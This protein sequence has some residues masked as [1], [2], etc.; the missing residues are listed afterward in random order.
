[1]SYCQKHHHS[2][3]AAPQLERRDRCFKIRVINCETRE[4][5]DA[6]DSCVYVALSYVWGAY[7]PQMTVPCSSDGSKS[8]H[9]PAELPR[10]IEDAII[11]YC[12]NQGDAR[13]LHRQLDL[14][15]LIYNF[16]A[17]TL[18][19]AAGDNASFGLPGVSHPR[20][21]Q[22]TIS[23]DGQLWVSALED[24]RRCV[25]RSTWN[26]RA[27]TFQ[28]G[29][30]ARQRL[31]FTTDQVAFECNGADFFE[32]ARRAYRNDGKDFQAGPGVDGLRQCPGAIPF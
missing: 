5:I 10:T 18:V 6:D 15:D 11:V 26:S 13:E 14:M 28:E 19:A 12:I 21:L 4:I 30:F 20:N 9:L 25:A 3:C 1:M 29:L 7:K 22:P 2:Q 16:A 32:L 31:L 17:L 23:V 27:W 8:I 24:P